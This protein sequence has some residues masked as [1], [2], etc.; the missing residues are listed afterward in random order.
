MNPISVDVALKFCELCNWTHECW[1]T[2]RRLFDDN[3]NDDE[4]IWGS[5]LFTERLS[6]ITQE[7]VLLQ[8]CKLHDPAIQKGSFNITIDYFVRFG[9][10]GSS[11]ARIKE[12][13]SQL[14]DLFEKLKSARNKMLAHH[15]LE[16]LMSSEVLGG[17]P[18][19]QDDQYFSVLQKLVDE[20]HA[21]WRGG[22]RP[23]DDFAGTEVDEFLSVLE[24]T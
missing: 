15:D 11:E 16:A 22:P 19:G 13:A 24:G 10:W 7:Y 23:F 17:F 14:N 3:R 5:M 12:L 8:I 21:K 6:K 9:D 4:T 20:V 18:K 1:Q 2:H